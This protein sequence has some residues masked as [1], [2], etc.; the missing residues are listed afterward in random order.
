MRRNAPVAQRRVAVMGAGSWGTTYAKILADAGNDV[1]LWAR[2]AEVAKEI[3]ETKRNSRYLT[4]INLPRNLHAT[5]S[6]AEA[7]D[8]ADEVYFCVPSQ[9]LRENLAAAARLMD[10]GTI[11]VSLMKGVRNSPVCA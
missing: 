6:L 10:N 1:T 8:G 2:R 9:A 5:N 3:E 11:A 7:F 4:G